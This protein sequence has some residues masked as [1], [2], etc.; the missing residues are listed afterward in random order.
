MAEMRRAN[1]QLAEQQQHAPAEA[2][3]IEHVD[4]SKPYIQMVRVRDRLTTCARGLPIARNSER[5]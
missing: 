1:E 2:F 4:T 3:D 5:A